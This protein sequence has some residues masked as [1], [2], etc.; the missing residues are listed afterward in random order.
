MGR[1][2]LPFQGVSQAALRPAWAI[3][4]AGTAPCCRMNSVMGR[5]ASTCA[6]DHIP[7]HQGVMRPSGQTAVASTITSAAPPTA[8]VP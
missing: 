7:V 5:K 8:R 4:M 6:S 3:W 2:L 1:N